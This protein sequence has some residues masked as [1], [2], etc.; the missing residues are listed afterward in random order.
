MSRISSPARFRCTGKA[1][2]LSHALLACSL[3]LAAG[4]HAADPAQDKAVQGAR[5]KFRQAIALQT[6][7]NWAGALALFRDVAGVKSTP[8]VRF[9]IAICEENLG[10]LVQAL[11][12]Y[13]LAAAEAREE[14][15]LEV[16][17]EVDGRLATLQ[18]R[19]PKV[20]IQHGTNAAR[21]K[22]SIDGVEVGSSMIGTKLPVDP[23]SH[24]VE[25]E[26]RGFQK[27]EKT[28]DAAEQQE[29]VVDVA[30]VAVPVGA[31]P[32]A[33]A[34]AAVDHSAVEAPRGT[35]YLPYVVGGV[36]AASLIASGVFLGLRQKTIGDLDAACGATRQGCPASLESTA[37][38]GRTYSTLAV[39]TLI[40]GVVGVGGGVVL[41]LTD[42]GPSKGAGTALRLVPEAPLAN[43]GASLVGRF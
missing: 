34:S 28:F 12:D 18:A 11:G 24:L 10:Q 19:I 23:G 1:R 6:G 21:A 31:E 2:A 36:G 14:G 41:L 9:N 27:F 15:S 30:M 3:M 22:I 13:Q 33:A 8:Q 35:N 17:G 40:A 37:S 7:G 25:A 39:V 20:V 16:A 5:Q 4:A 29:I 43:A 42:H 26:A 32:A 38:S